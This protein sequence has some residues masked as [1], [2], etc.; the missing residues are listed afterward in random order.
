V[1]KNL[2]FY[3]FLC[4]CAGVVVGYH[5][6]SFIVLGTSAT[7]SLCLIYLFYKKGKIILSDVSILLFFLFLGGLW[8]SLSLPYQIDRFLKDEHY[9]TLKVTSLPYDQELRN[10]F[11][12]YIRKGNS[13]PLGLKARVMD[14]TKEMEYL[15]SYQ[16]K[17]KLRKLRGAKTG[18]Y[19]LWVKS[20]TPIKKLPISIWDGFTQRIV[21]HIL[22]LYRENVSEQSLAFLSA[23][24]LGRR[25]LLSKEVKS[26]F[27]E[28]GAA[29][30]LAISG[31]HMS[32]VSLILFYILKFFNIKFRPRLA[33][34]ILFL[35]LYTFLIGPK[36]ATLRAGIMYS[37]FGVS[38]LMKRRVCPLNSLG[39][40]GLISLF[41]NPL[42]ISDIGFQLSFMAVFGIIFGYRFFNI[43]IRSK[44]LFLTYLKNIFF[45]SLLVFI[46]IWPLSSYYFDRIHIFSILSNLVLIPIFSFIIFTNF[47]LLIFSP[48]SFLAK[49]VGEAISFII[50]VFI[51]IAH[52]FASLKVPSINLGISLGGVILYYL[53]LSVGLLLFNLFIKSKPSYASGV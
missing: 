7:A 9:F 5:L 21:H 53:I 47:I 23:V 1:R 2:N 17:G 22:S 36:P 35:L 13:T 8:V 6:P 51:E 4:F 45:S 26:I 48:F 28:A 52:F 3:L 16:V 12:A 31:L 11:L 40:A 10:T 33:I 30:L 37:V 29:H 50:F 24:L 20:T 25:E 32:L 49:L 27:R 18:F 34:S 39:L 14:Y 41:I 43:R 46:F 42:W 19:S 38:L 15:H 44:T